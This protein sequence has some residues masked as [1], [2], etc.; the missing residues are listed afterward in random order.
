[1]LALVCCCVFEETGLLVFLKNTNFPET[2]ISVRGLRLVRHRDSPWENKA[3]L[4]EFLSVGAIDEPDPMQV[5]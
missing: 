5:L 1:M 4:C 3:N 2:T